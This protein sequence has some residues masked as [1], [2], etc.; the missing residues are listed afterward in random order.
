MKIVTFRMFSLG[1]AI[2]TLMLACSI[3]WALNHPSQA[4]DQETGQVATGMQLNAPHGLAITPSDI[5]YISTFKDGQIHRLDLRTGLMTV[6]KTR[7]SIMGVVDILLDSSGN[8]IAGNPFQCRVVRINVADGS[9][10]TIV[11]REQS[12]G[13]HGCGSDGDGGLALQ[14]SLEPDFIAQDVHGNLFIVDGIP[15]GRVRRV[16]NKSGII[17]TVAAP[18]LLVGLQTVAVAGQGTLFLSQ[19]GKGTQGRTLLS[20]VT[21][22]GSLNTLK[23]SSFGGNKD[24]W[25]ESMGPRRLFSDPLGNLYLL[26]ESRVF[27]MDMSKHFVSIVAGSTKGF[28]GDGG[29]AA[30][31]EMFW[32]TSVVLDSAGNLYIADSENQRVRRVDVGTHVITTVAGN[33]GPAHVPGTIELTM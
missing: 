12:A 15:K 30:Q 14:A 24:F 25:A 7:S 26:D 10:E 31:A 21:S 6:L 3:G 11:G 4:G 23:A 5:L 19:V 27:Y 1:F 28:G 20:M 13:S 18:P 22:T 9:V 33:G 29:P 32:P 16:D 17:S 2:C 8:L